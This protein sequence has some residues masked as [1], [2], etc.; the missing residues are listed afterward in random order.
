MKLVRDIQ[1][2][3][4]FKRDTAKF[5]KQMRKTKQPVVLTVNGTAAIVVQDAESYQELLDA[6]ERMEAIEGIQRGLDSLKDGKSRTAKRFFAA[7]FSKHNI[8]EE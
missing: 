7:L 1:S 6:K 4:T 2:L 5:L 3:S 8:P